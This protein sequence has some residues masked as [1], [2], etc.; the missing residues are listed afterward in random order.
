MRLHVSPGT[1]SMHHQ[2]GRGTCLSFEFMGG[3]MRVTNET[4]INY[5]IIIIYL[6]GG[7]DYFYRVCAFV[8]DK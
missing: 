8:L 4:I 6:S 3:A 2:D 5:Y 1:H 7:R